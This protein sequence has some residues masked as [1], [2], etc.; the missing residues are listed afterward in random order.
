MSRWNP[1]KRYESSP[2]SY[3]IWQTG[4]PRPTSWHRFEPESWRLRNDSQ[5]LHLAHGEVKEHAVE[6]FNT[7]GLAEWASR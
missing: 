6:S 4:I 3:V 5:N 2:R 1:K 7:S